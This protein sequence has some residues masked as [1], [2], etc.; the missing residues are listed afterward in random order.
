MELFTV[1]LIINGPLEMTPGKIAAQT[2][3]ACQRLFVK[4]GECED[5]AEL[6][7]KWQASNTKTIVR[8]AETEHV[9]AR[10]CEELDGVLMVDEGKNEVE[11]GSATVFA[12]MPI[13][14][15][16]KV[17]QMIT[18]KKMPMLTTIKCKSCGS[19]S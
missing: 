15:S 3:Q 2:F 8:I 9:F 6:I 10:A 1:Y 17:P 11:P 5:T 19:T 12:T 16:G 13:S 18:H 7:A 14:R 4:A